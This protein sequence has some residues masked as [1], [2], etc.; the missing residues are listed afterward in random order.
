MLRKVDSDI[1]ANGVRKGEKLE[2]GAI[3]ERWQ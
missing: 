1:V 3:T 2:G